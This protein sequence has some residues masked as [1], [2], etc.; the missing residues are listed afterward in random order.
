MPLPRPDPDERVLSWLL[1]LQTVGEGDTQRR[2]REEGE[3]R[4]ERRGER[5]ASEY[6]LPRY[7]P[8]HAMLCCVVLVLCRCYQ[9]CQT[10]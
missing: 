10:H 7:V 3:G 8:C 9:R 2:K 1:L 6:Y 5:R 4:K